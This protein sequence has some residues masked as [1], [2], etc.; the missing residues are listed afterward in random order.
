MKTLSKDNGPEN[1]MGCIAFSKLNT[2]DSGNFCPAPQQEQRFV[3]LFFINYLF[4]E[5]LLCT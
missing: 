2:S 5:K 1:F 3:F 4:E